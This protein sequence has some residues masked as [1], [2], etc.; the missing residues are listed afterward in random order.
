MKGLERGEKDLKT[1]RDKAC[2][3]SGLGDRE[4]IQKRGF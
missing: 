2:L 1:G 3:V 4:Q